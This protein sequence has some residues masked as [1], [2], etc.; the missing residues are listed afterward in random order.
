MYSHFI[1]AMGLIPS[2]PD[3]QTQKSE[4]ILAQICDSMMEKIDKKYSQKDS[5]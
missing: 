2:A 1:V 4:L 5:L 3:G